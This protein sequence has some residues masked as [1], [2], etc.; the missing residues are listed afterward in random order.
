MRILFLTDNYP[1][2]VNAPA[3]RT[4]E[5]CVE[6]VK[7]GNDVT[8]ITCW[9]N[10]PGGVVYKG[11]HNKLYG[12]TDANGIKVKR[13]WTYISRNEG[14]LRR[15]SDYLSFAV[16]SFFVGLFTPCDVIV[17]KKVVVKF[18]SKLVTTIE[19]ENSVPD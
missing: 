8:V 18:R 13:V 1:P 12:R 3:R 16:A 19:Y 6:W 2:E 9:P 14:F 4:Y 11:Y 5:H 7:V 17:A 15:T 10:F